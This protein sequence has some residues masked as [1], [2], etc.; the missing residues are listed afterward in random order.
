MLSTTGQAEV[1]IRDVRPGRRVLPPATCN[2]ILRDDLFLGDKTGRV[3]QIEVKKGRVAEV[4]KDDKP[5][6]INCMF[7]AL[8]F[9]WTGHEDALIRQWTIQTGDKFRE[10]KGHRGSILSLAIMGKSLFSGSQDGFIYQW[11]L[12][13]GD[14][15]NFMPMTRPVLCLAVWPSAEL[16]IA[17]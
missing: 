14:G 5:S 6:P 12:V 4:F 9:V 8:G 17:G 7:A 13:T 3:Y 2:A 1:K 10:M 11:D 16:L 15:C